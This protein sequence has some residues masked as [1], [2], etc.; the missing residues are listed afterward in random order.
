MSV[1]FIAYDEPVFDEETG[2]HIKTKI[3]G[4]TERE[5]ILRQHKTANSRGHY[6]NNDIEALQDFIT[7]NWAWI[8]EIP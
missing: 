6:Y 2:E 3:M 8:V 7:I 5:A 1:K 4:I